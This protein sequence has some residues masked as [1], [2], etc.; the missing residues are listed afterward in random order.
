MWF[1]WNVRGVP[2]TRFSLVYRLIR[3]FSLLLL[4]IVLLSPINDVIQGIIA[5]LA[6]L[7]FVAGF[8]I[9]LGAGKCNQNSFISLFISLFSLL[10]VCWTVM[11]EIM[12]TRLR[13]KAVSLF[14]SVNWAT[15]LLIAMLT[16][17]AIDG[18]G[19]VSDDMTDDNQKDHEKIGVGALYLVFAGMT[20]ACFAFIYFYVPETKGS[21]LMLIEIISWLSFFL[22]VWSPL[23]LFR[24][25]C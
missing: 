15:N 4:S 16:L 9:G 22:L 2:F 18:L 5:V 13:A 21:V 25:N 12:P 6:I 1:C 11:S 7:F 17:T 14:L 20:A 10:L 24:Q 3:L 8:A 19:G 23:L